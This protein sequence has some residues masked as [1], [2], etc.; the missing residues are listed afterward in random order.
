ML[1]A[2]GRQDFDTRQAFEQM[3]GLQI[4]LI[5]DIDIAG[6][7]RALPRRRIE[8]G[9]H[10]NAIEMRPAALPVIRIAFKIYKLPK[11]SLLQKIWTI[12]H[13]NPRLSPIQ[14]PFKHT[15]GTTHFR[16]LT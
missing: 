15:T 3:N 1:G 2:G 5:D 9:Q 4:D 11:L 14:R 8:N 10:F 6:S 13:H 7:E 12:I 16:I